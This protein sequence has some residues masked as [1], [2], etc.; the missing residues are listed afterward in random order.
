MCVRVYILTF[1]KKFSEAGRWTVIFWSW[2]YRHSWAVQHGYWK[3]NTGPLPEQPVL[4]GSQPYLQPPLHC[5]HGSS[6]SFTIRMILIFN[7]PYT[8]F[9]THKILESVIPKCHLW[10][11]S[12]LYFWPVKTKRAHIS[13]KSVS[14]GVWLQILKAR[15]LLL[16][17][18]RIKQSLLKPQNNIYICSS[19]CLVYSLLFSAVGTESPTLGR[20]PHS[21]SSCHQ[22]P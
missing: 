7:F 9:F 5:L 8:C 20:W 15:G 21:V 13:W 6:Y 19:K 11:F 1:V 22:H 2:S 18:L 3:P 14:T 4:S 17:D 12:L 16:W 10:F